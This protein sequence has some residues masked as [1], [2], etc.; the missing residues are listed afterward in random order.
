MSPRSFY[1]LLFLSLFSLVAATGVWI[2][3][4]DHSTKAFFGEPLLPELMEK[5]NTV[6]VIS[7]EHGGQ[8][9]TFVH[10]A[11]GDWTLMEENGYPADKDRIRNLLIGLAHLEKIEPKTALPEFYTD[12]HVEDNTAE[13][14]QSYL[15]TLLNADGEQITSLLIGKKISGITWDGQGYF[16]RF[17]NNARS[18][19]VRGNVDATGDKLSWLPVRILPLVKGRTASVTLV[20]G[21]KTREIVYKRSDPDM[22]MQVFFMSDSH[23]MI[24]RNFIDTMEKALTSFD[25]SGAIKRPADLENDPPFTS[26]MIETIDGLNIFMFL[27]LID[28]Q[29]YAAVSFDFSDT[30]QEPVQKE[31]IDLNKQHGRWLYEISSETV[32]ALLPFLSV[33]E[34]KKAEKAQPAKK[35]AAKKKAKKQTK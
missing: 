1:K 28:S 32:S 3:T 7:I 9:L 6:E 31:A 25:F 4:P 15:V 23:F 27:Y 8:T 30:A 14:S 20:D 34:E 5:I 12:L 10:N 24:S 2:L 18:W 11:D 29:P 22:P 21:T 26:V 19:L 13:K 17:P 33:P 35:A 16:V